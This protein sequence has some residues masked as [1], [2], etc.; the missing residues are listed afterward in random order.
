MAFDWHF[1]TGEYPVNPTSRRCFRGPMIDVEVI[2]S[3]P[4]SFFEQYNTLR[5]AVM[6]H[7]VDTTLVSVRTREIVLR[8][9]NNMLG[10]I[11]ARLTPQKKALQ[12]IICEKRDS[13]SIDSKLAYLDP[14]FRTAILDLRR[15]SIPQQ[16]VALLLSAFES[17][18]PVLR[19]A[20]RCATILL[21]SYLEMDV[22]NA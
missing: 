20:G 1:Y 8:T 4:F 5:V 2:M 12:A 3:K 7:V 10:P 11:F 18:S 14:Y 19:V 15:Y 21:Y 13:V 6:D 17:A 22:Q 9:L 16:Q